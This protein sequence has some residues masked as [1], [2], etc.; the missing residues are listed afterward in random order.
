MQYPGSSRIFRK[1]TNFMQNPEMNFKMQKSNNFRTKSGKSNLNKNA[2]IYPNTT[3]NRNNNN[4]K[5]YQSAKNK[6]KNNY[7]IRMVLCLKMLGIG[8]LQKIFETKN[9]TF[10]EL[11]ILSMK[12]LANLGIKKEEQI[13]IK[14]FSLDY[15]KNGSYF[16]LDELDNSELLTD[17]GF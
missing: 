6:N 7:D 8:Y 4:Y 1:S 9:I 11:L 17:R 5:R 2:H 15:I 3:S 16:S 10:D 12:D 13:I 14:K